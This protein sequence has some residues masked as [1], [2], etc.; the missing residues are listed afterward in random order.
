MT[1]RPSRHVESP[2]RWDLSARPTFDISAPFWCPSTV[3]AYKCVTGEMQWRVRVVALGRAALDL[4]PARGEQ[5]NGFFPGMVDPTS[6]RGSAHSLAQALDSGVN[7][8]FRQGCCHVC[9][10]PHLLVCRFLS[11]V[12][13]YS[14]SNPYQLL[15][16]VR[17]RHWVIRIPT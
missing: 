7:K 12:G 9:L 11:S 4:S 13:P 10:L 16:R 15:Y 5:G 3:F 6:G 17:I 8:V 2:Q 14:T 1:P